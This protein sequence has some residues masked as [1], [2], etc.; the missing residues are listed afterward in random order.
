MS[1]NA[2]ASSHVEALN[3]AVSVSCDFVLHL[4]SFENQQGFASFN[5]LTFGSNEL[6]DFARHRS[7]DGV[8][9]STS[10]YSSLFRCSRSGRTPF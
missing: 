8:L 10:G 6:H 5:S 1:L 7:I 2:L 9:T 3:N 4:H